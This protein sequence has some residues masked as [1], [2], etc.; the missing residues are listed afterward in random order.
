MR[1]EMPY[2]TLCIG[3]GIL[4]KAAPWPFPARPANPSLR[5]LCIQQVVLRTLMLHC[6]FSQIKPYDACPSMLVCRLLTAALWGSLVVQLL[7]V[8]NQHRLR[9]LR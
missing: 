8:P 4:G 6:R 3:R 9:A 7:L 2:I 1:A 5:G